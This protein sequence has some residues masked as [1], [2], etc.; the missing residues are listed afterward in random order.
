MKQK[1]PPPSSRVFCYL[2]VVLTGKRAVKDV[3]FL[4][5][6]KDNVLAGFRTAGAAAET[7]QGTK[8]RSVLSLQDRSVRCLGDNAG[9][10]CD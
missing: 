1:H 4:S 10:F 6:D 2:A 5:V 9:S 7:N 3:S 8:F